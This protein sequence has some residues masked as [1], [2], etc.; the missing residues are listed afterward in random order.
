MAVINVAFDDKSLPMNTQ[1]RSAI[2]RASVS[3]FVIAA[4]S[5]L[6]VLR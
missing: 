2:D 4:A 3:R 6:P 1:L 5:L